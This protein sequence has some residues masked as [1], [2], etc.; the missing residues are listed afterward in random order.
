[1]LRPAAASALFVLLLW[2]APP[3]AVAGTASYAV[4]DQAIVNIVMR[5]NADIEVRTWDTPAVAAGWGD[6][7]P[8][9]ASKHS[10]V[11]QQPGFTIPRTTIRVGRFPDGVANIDLPPE[12][13]PV[14]NIA[15]GAHDDVAIR[16]PL[17]AP[18]AAGPFET[19]HL[20]V[21]IPAS[22]RVLIVRETS[23]TIAI[24]DFRGTAIINALSSRVT[25][26]NLQGDAFAQV[27]NGS[28]TAQDSSFG[29]LRVRSNNASLIFERCNS[30]QIDAS[31]YAGDVVYDDGTFDPG[32]AHF[33]SARGNIA[34]GVNGSVQLAGRSTDGRVYTMFDGHSTIDQR[35]PTDANAR[36][37]IGGP[38]VNAVS[39]HGS[40][41]LYDGSV[42]SHGV[43]PPEWQP[44]RS[45]LGGT[46]RGGAFPVR[47][48][49]RRVVR[50]ET[51]A[52]SRRRV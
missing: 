32:L 24:H 34:L 7:D 15:S 1:M 23:G 11:W 46:R 38:L 4:G 50:G 18:E 48:R 3:G 22:T 12:E 10:Y 47:P 41:F 2:C 20:T 6:N 27:L 8:I 40:V 42:T 19:R 35:S 17:T 13:F 26:E 21:V 45:A 28:F 43:L 30:K 37:G 9:V 25:L 51:S 44:V 29:R 36:L 14:D 49:L 5:G 31:T 39:E 16:E 52:S 33:T